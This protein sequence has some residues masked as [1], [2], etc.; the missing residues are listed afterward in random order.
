MI[1]FHIISADP[2]AIQALRKARTLQYLLI[3]DSYDFHA[4]LDYVTTDQLP[5]FESQICDLIL[6]YSADGLLFTNLNSKYN[7]RIRYKI[8]H[9]RSIWPVVPLL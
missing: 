5:N 8:S 2:E 7:V 6:K 1:I 3:I 9:T 4:I